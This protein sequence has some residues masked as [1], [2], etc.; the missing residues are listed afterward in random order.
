MFWNILRMESDKVF[1]RRL[2]WIG[3]V[4][5]LALTSI[6][7]LIIFNVDHSASNA[8]YWVWPGGLT[9]ALAFANGYSP[10]Y[11]YAAYVLAVVAGLVTGQEYSWRTMQLWL[12]HGVP[13]PLL[14][15][16]KFVL[17]LAAVLLVVL[18]FM[19]VGA[20]VSIILTYQPHG[21]TNTNALDVG[22]LLL[23]YLR[24]CYGLLPYVSLTFLLVIVSRS[25][26]VAI[27]G[28]I[29]FMLAIELPLTGILPRLG[30]GYA[31]AV[32]FLPFG[33]AQAMNQQ[34]YAAAHLPM[35]TF[36]SAG[37][38]NPVVAAICIAVYTLAFCGIALW[39]FQ[40]QNLTN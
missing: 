17:A 28:V 1:R 13:R 5:V 35:T 24:T 18:A 25:A 9:S 4:I 27:S 23:S 26:V 16:A 3:L 37:Q 10:G 11:G 34:N 40:R 33:L 32:Q 30:S 2:L 38:V 31:Q 39:V 7:F 21:G 14:L 15:L 20:L 8:R 12:S 29:L 19:L 36:V 6:F 22:A